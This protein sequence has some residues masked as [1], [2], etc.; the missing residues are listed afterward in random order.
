VR[1][2]ARDDSVRYTHFAKCRGDKFVALV[3]PG[4]SH[5]A[6]SSMRNKPRL[7]TR[8]RRVRTSVVARVWRVPGLCSWLQNARRPVTGT[9]WKR[10]S[11]GDGGESDTEP[12]VAAVSSIG[13]CRPL[14]RPLGMVAMSGARHHPTAIRSAGR[15][16]R[17]APPPPLLETADLHAR[18]TLEFA[19]D[20]IASLTHERSSNQV[21]RPSG[22]RPP[23]ARTFTAAR[24]PDA[25]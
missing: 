16:H 20:A 12:H 2:L 1:T 11:L 4:P 23:K 14:L 17:V 9:R 15:R 22:S 21:E 3:R 25:R 24:W 8:H 10:E 7:A 5:C 18:L 13:C 19:G 6:A